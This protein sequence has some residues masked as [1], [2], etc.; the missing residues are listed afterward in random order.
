MSVDDP[1]AGRVGVGHIV[2]ESVE[3][4]LA[5]PLS[6]LIAVV[7]AVV[8][9]VPLVGTVLNTLT[10]G[11]IVH[12]VDGEF[13]DGRPGVGEL[14]YRLVVLVAAYVAA[15]VAIGIGFLLLILPGLY[16]ALRFTLFVP[17]VVLGGH[18]PLSA[19]SYSYDLTEGHLL[20]VLGVGL[21]FSVPVIGAFAALALFYG[22]EEFGRALVQRDLRVL[23]TVAV[24]LS[25]FTA[26]GSAT[27]V[28]MYRRF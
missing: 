1:I 15:V 5:R 14:G 8:G 18:G 26:I 19:L 2:S 12:V 13:R 4:A 21:V 6:F 25:P 23:A 22:F 9:Q 28:V 20:T 10:S 24:V 17:A 27:Q 11:T 3:A 16:L 7:G